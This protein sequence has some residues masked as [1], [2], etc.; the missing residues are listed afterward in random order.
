MGKRKSSLVVVKILIILTL[1]RMFLLLILIAASLFILRWL[2]VRV[3]KRLLVVRP[4]SGIGEHR[5]RK[6]LY[7]GRTK[8]SRFIPVPHRFIYPVVYAGLDLTKSAKEISATFFS[9]FS[10]QIV[11][12]YAKDFLGN[13]GGTFGDLHVRVCKHLASK[14]VSDVDRIHLVSMPRL[15]G[16]SFNPVNFYFCF[17]SV[18]KFTALLLEV[19]NTFGE[20]HVY[21]VSGRLN[22]DETRPWLKSSM[23]RQFHVSPFNDISGTYDIKC[24]PPSPV[25]DLCVDIWYKENGE[26]KF[27]ADIQARQLACSAWSLL[28]ILLDYPFTILLTFPRI[29]YQAFQLAYGKYLH[30]YP[31]PTPIA[32]DTIVKLAPSKFELFATNICLAYLNHFLI[33]ESYGMSIEFKLDSLKNSFSLI[34]GPGGDSS[35]SIVVNLLDYDLFVWLLLH[36]NAE[37]S[38][39]ITLDNKSWNCDE[40]SLVRQLLIGAFTPLPSTDTPLMSLFRQR[41]IE[42]FLYCSSSSTCC[43]GSSSAKYHVLDTFYHLSAC[44]RWQYYF[45]VAVGALELYTHHSIFNALTPWPESK[46]P[47]PWDRLNSFRQKIK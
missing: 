21:V 6:M 15:L 3:L 39:Q 40:L 37:E 29:L 30:V 42:K 34:V 32:D 8:H 45:K 22:N 46:R 18:Q 1:K 26:Q 27:Y 11:T 31:K 7:L 16:Y 24:C 12:F 10:L 14:G 25:R 9:L 2:L 38:I 17:D 33:E 5:E 36:N 28:F 20:S 13:V 19:N 43:Q 47:A 41:F 23:D 35:K 4:E 44:A